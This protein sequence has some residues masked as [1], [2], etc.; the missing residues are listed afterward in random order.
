MVWP[1]KSLFRPVR[2]LG[3]GRVRIFG[4]AEKVI[5]VDEKLFKI[6]IKYKL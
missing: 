6:F 5:E 3:V 4:A 2:T 1:I